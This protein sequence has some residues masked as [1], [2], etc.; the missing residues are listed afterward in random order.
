MSTSIIAWCFKAQA[1]SKGDGVHTVALSL[2]E[3]KTSVKTLTAS[4][5]YSLTA[6]IRGV[7]P[8][9]SSAFFSE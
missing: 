9:S 2:A 3:A 1:N 5:F 6:S 8:A 7:F 4:M